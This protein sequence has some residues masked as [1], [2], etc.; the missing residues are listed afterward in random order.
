MIILADHRIPPPAKEKLAR[1]GSLIEVGSD[2]IVYDAISGH[3]DIFFFKSENAL[4]AA[5]YAL[6]KYKQDFSNAG[7]DV[8]SGSENPNGHYP[9]SA[10]YNA[11]VSRDFLIHRSGITDSSIT[12]ACADKEFISVRQGYC[13]CSTIPLKNNEFIT[14]DMGIYKT[15]S[16][17]GITV[18]YINSQ[19]VLLPGFKHGFLGGAC[20]VYGDVA[21]F[22]GSL[23]CGS[24]GN[25][26]DILK[27]RGYEIVE[28]YSGPL[29][30]CGSILFV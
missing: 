9:A 23:K 15:L 24:Y 16:S 14:S 29:F 26:A 25:I 4:I 2:G 6:E 3:P 11:L 18:Y 8:I 20:G 22:C 13:R 27:L 12:M 17:K 28:L 1:Y 21:F 5:P 30:D 7:I 10:R 19:D